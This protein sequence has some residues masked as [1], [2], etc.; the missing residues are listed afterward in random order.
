MLATTVG[1]AVGGT[2]DGLVGGWVDVA[3]GI[4]AC[5]VVGWAIVGAAQWLVLRKRVYRSGWWVLASTEGRAVGWA[6]GFVDVAVG[7]VV[8][9][10]VGEAVVG[11]ILGF[12][13]IMLLRHPRDIPPIEA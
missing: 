6:V 3:G 5:L 12:V 11:T 10:A 1:G 2:G 4:L 9:A 13:L 7:W 8:G